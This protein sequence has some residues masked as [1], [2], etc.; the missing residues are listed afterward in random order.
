MATIAPEL[1]G[2]TFRKL[3]GSGGFA[4]VYHYV[5]DDLGRDVAI[6]VLKRTVNEKSLQAF[7]TEGTLMAKLSGHP[8]I[9][10]IHNSGVAADGRPYLVMELCRADNLG[11]RIARRVLAPD[12][13]LEL[14]VALAGAI[15]TA[16]R[17]GVLHRDIKPA[18]ILFTQ[19][20]MPALTDFGIS[21]SLDGGA[22]A[23][24][25]LSPQWAPPEQ[26]GDMEAGIGPW[27]DVYS[28][29][30]T[31]WAMLVG[32]SPLIGP[33]EVA[34]AL[35]IR[36]RQ[37]RPLPPTGRPDVPSDL[38][39]V[40]AVGLASRPEERFG[41]ALELARA[42]QDVQTRLRRTATQLI[43]LS[44]EEEVEREFDASDGRTRFQNFRLIDPDPTGT[45]TGPAGGHTVTYD[46]PETTAD[47]P[48]TNI[49][50]HGRGVAQP[51]LRDFTH[52]EIPEVATQADEPE[53]VAPPIPEPPKRLRPLLLGVG[54][55]IGVAA[56]VVGGFLLLGRG[57]AS[58]TSD[59]TRSPVSGTAKPGDPVRATVPKV[60]DI[61]GKFVGDEASFTWTNPEPEPGDKYKYQLV[62]PRGQTAPALIE[63]AAVTVPKLAGDTCVEVFLV[64]ANGRASQ[65]SRGCAS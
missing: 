36:A 35:K 56:L 7:R 63:E 3:L 30:A 25:A 16:H 24:K 57:G 23:S 55:G 10:T 32:H 51:G 6:K 33:G 38:E 12:R 13:A 64:R 8:N 41:S 21:V 62:D 60:T 26:F 28:L 5:Q 40:L 11:D 1:P 50:R 29:A 44:D 20:D 31:L 59:P 42:L 52:L 15:E 46:R 17:L 54:A 39:R 49:L 9:V 65:P 27:S 37:A 22:R 48:A 45:A 47:I 53:P 4:D 19:A 14:I 61:S 18:N 34:D 2:Y 43:I 58:T